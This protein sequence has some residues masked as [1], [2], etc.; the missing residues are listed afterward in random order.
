LTFNRIGPIGAALF[1]WTALT[2]LTTIEQALNRV[3]QAPTSRSTARRV[4]LYWSAMTLSPVALAIASYLGHQALDRFR[5][6]SV[7]S[8]FLAA[9]G[10]AGQIVV[11]VLVVSAA[12]IL[13]PNTRVRRRA[14]LGGAFV[15]VLLWMIAKWAFSLYVQHLVVGGN[16]YGI[17]G[18]LRCGCT[19][20]G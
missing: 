16:L 7:L 1:I 15:A 17:L 20:H 3:F 11:G 9:A 6:W 2:L 18:V 12:Y 14:A 10:W 13:M 4:L 19:S 5:S 8:W